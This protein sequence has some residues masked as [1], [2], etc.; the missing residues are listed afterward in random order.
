MNNSPIPIIL[1]D[2]GA[3]DQP[4]RLSAW[5]VEPGDEVEPGD[6]VVEVLVAGMTCDI[7]SPAAGRISRLEKELD[8]N[9]H[10]GDVLA[11]IEPA[12]EEVE[13]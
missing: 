12:K 4:L 5:F 13:H 10:P 7:P 6:R 8:A 3:G 1:P 9:V 11:W 2:L